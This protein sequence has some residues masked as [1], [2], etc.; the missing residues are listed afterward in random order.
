MMISGKAG[1]NL[2]TIQPINP[3]NVSENHSNVLISIFTSL[4]ESINR[5]KTGCGFTE[6]KPGGTKDVREQGLA[7]GQDE[8][9]IFQFVPTLTGGLTTSRQ[10]HFHFYAKEKY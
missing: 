5:A 2:P 3:P 8:N 10:E 9:N 1:S 7:T 4:S 6:E